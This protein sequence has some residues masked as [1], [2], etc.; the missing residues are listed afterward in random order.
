MGVRLVEIDVHQVL[1]SLRV[2]HCGGLHVDALNKLV[3]AMNYVAR[4]LGYDIQWDTET[5]GCDPSLSSIPADYQRLFVDALTEIKAWMDVPRNAREFILIYLDDEPDLLAWGVV[6]RLIEEIRG[7]FGDDEIYKPTDSRDRAG[8]A[9]RD[10]TASHSDWPSWP[11]FGDLLDRGFRTMFV[12]SSDYGHQMA[13]HVFPRG[14]DVCNWQEPGLH[15]IDTSTCEG[16]YEEGVFLRIPSCQIQYGP[17]NCDFDLQKDNSPFLDEEM[18]R[19]LVS[20]GLSMPAPDLL[21]PERAAAAIWTWAPGYPEDS[22]GRCDDVTFVA[23]TDGRWRTAG[24]GCDEVE[25]LPLACRRAGAPPSR[26]NW[27]F[28]RAEVGE[29]PSGTIAG[30]PRHARENAALVDAMRDAQLVG[31]RI[32]V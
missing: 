21:T 23:A 29:C 22:G 32:V 25:R 31:A 7:V 8:D 13:S 14:P 28:A 30:P 9:L 27:V 17:L 11:S 16:A 5:V 26:P 2:A 19:D 3:R 12:S 4:T 1:G 15:D 6:P 20:C 24:D 18:L 10:E